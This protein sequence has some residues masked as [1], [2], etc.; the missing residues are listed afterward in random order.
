MVD[1]PIAGRIMV[2]NSPN[3]ANIGDGSSAGAVLPPF[4]TTERDAIS[5]PKDGAMI[6]NSTQDFINIFFQGAWQIFKYSNYEE[7]N[8]Q[9]TTTSTTPQLIFTSTFITPD[10]AIYTLKP[11]YGAAAEKKD[12]SHIVRIDLDD[13]EIH[14]FTTY[15]VGTDDD[16]DANEPMTWESD[17]VLTAG[18]H[19]LKMYLSSG[20]AGKEVIVNDK[21]FIVEFREAT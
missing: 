17:H 8:T 10:V 9:A 1:L 3:G 5:S 15:P 19:T 6:Y 13:V 2:H 21:T 11:L 4:T 7:E 16:D 14:T 18:S 12:K 20:E